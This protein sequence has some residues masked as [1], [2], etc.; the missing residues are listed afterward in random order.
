MLFTTLYLKMKDPPQGRSLGWVGGQSLRFGTATPMAKEPE[1]TDIANAATEIF[2]TGSV[3][4]KTTNRETRLTPVARA[5][6]TVQKDN[7][8]MLDPFQLG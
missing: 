2:E 6:K 3:V 7:E 4:N 1:A 5:T 8:F